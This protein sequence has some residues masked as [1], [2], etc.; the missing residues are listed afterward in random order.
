MA[1]RALFLDR[2]G[3]VNLDNAY[4]HRKEDFV[5]LDGIFDVCRKARELGYLVIVATNQSGIERG[6]FTEDEFREL[7]DWMVARFA[8]EGVA[9]TD[10]LYC[11][12]LSGNDRKPNPGMFL[13]AADRYGLDMPNSVS[14]GDKERDIE[15]A[16]RAG[17]G[18]NVLYSDAPGET[19]ADRVI[20][21]LRE[22]E[23]VL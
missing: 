23:M 19:A 8:E 2:D 11:P 18:T 15:A 22:M 17:V 4:V 14:L 9:I 3:V 20:R 7:T 6:Y 13:T 10:V 1:S 16:R 21:N 5:F 12:G